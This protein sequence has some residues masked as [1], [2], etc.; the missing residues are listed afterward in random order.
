MLRV[1]LEALMHCEQLDQCELV[2][3]DLNSDDDTYSLLQQYAHKLS[4]NHLLIPYNGLFLRSKALNC[5]ILHSQGHI[6]SIL[7]TDCIPMP[8]FLK[9]IH[10]FYDDPQNADKKIC[11]HMVLV[12][13]HS[14]GLVRCNETY[15]KYTKW[16]WDFKVTKI[17]VFPT[18]MDDKRVGNSQTSML[19]SNFL[20]VGG[21]A[22]TFEGYGWED[23]EFG[24]RCHNHFGETIMLDHVYH[25]FHPPQQDRWQNAEAIKGTKQ[26]FI[27]Q[28]D[29]GFPNPVMDDSW[30]NFE[31][32]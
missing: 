11:R 15:E 30:G 23:F 19:R 13:P 25:M 28:R 7:D 12:D 1:F 26:A 18:L 22:E 20:K 6:V 5:G 4:I 3:V 32:C 27:E 16:L 21:F 2:L 14:S 31:G 24:M 9:T 10:E 8:H 29:K 17:N